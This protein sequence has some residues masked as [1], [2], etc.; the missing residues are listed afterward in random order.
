MGDA[1]SRGH[2][3]TVYQT[4]DPT[5][6]SW[7]Q[8][9]HDTAL[10][11][12]AAHAIDPATPLIDV[13]GGASTLAAQLLSAGHTDVT[14]LDIA[15]AAIARARAGLGP[16][17]T[18]HFIVADVTAWQPARR[19]GVWHDRAAFHFLTDP[20]QQ[21]AYLAALRAATDPGSTV[22]IATF[23]PDGPERC[24][25]LPVQR[26]SLATLAARFG[27]DFSP[28]EERREHHRTPGGAV[29][30]F[31]WHVLRRA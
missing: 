19:W 30:E 22:I 12:I 2:W 17:Q 4:K 13:G 27:E 23:A 18:A 11:L 26:Y 8:P 28:I 6:V 21:D 25:G 15:E 3:E 29:Q 5:R 7:Y 9:R 31:A 24:S 20:G 16:G 10:S 14:V 1:D